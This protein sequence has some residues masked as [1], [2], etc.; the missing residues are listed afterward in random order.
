MFRQHDE[1]VAKGL[2][3]PDVSDHIGAVR[4]SRAWAPTTAADVL[5]EES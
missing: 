1:I 2:T 3:G 5:E 4:G